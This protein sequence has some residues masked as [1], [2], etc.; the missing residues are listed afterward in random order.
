MDEKKT[1]RKNY[2]SPKDER[3]EQRNKIFLKSLKRQGSMS[4]Q[5]QQEGK[6]ATALYIYIRDNEVCL[7]KTSK[8]VNMQ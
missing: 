2:L 3:K 4:K 1:S 7:N 8:K 5:N 6:H